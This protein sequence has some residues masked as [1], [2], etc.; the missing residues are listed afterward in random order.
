[1][2]RDCYGTELW[3][4]PARLV[5]FCSGFREQHELGNGRVIISGS[6]QYQLCFY[7]QR[8]LK[9]QFRWARFLG[10]GTPLLVDL[11]R[12]TQLFVIANVYTNKYIWESS[13]YDPWAVFVCICEMFLCIYSSSV[14][15]PHIEINM[16]IEFC[17][18]GTHPN[19]NI[20]GEGLWTSQ[21][22]K[23][24]TGKARIC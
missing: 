24:I 23:V 2:W 13:L 1:M 3:L 18:S 15:V 22:N 20:L 21:L 12:Y 19:I 5:C 4:D 6:F 8:F 10:F 14:Y 9:N 16:L 17:W 11:I 7:N